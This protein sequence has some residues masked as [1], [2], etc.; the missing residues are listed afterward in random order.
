MRVLEKYSHESNRQ[1]IRGN[2]VVITYAIL[3]FLLIFAV[4]FYK[5]GYLPKV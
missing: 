1:R 4:A 2:A 5:P 3:S